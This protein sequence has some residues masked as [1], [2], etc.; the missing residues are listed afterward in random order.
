M[1]IQSAKP[2]KQRRFRFNAPLHV[3]QKFVHAH[4]AKDLA[5]K[6][7]IKKRSVAVREGDTVKIMAGKQKGKSGKVSAVDLVSGRIYVEGIAR[8]TMKG[9]EKLIPISSSNV[10]LVELEISDKLRQEKLNQFK[11]VVK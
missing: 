8:K 5:K 11:I 4:I 3:R 6:L 10:Y 9:K 1:F 7:G 2:R